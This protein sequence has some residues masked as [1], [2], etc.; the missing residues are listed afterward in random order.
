MRRMRFTRESLRL[1]G[2]FALGLA[3]L[4]LFA[5]SLAALG[6]TLPAADAL[7]THHDHADHGWSE[8][9]RVTGKPFHW[10]GPIAPGRTVTIRGIHGGVHVEPAVG[11]QVAVDARK[12][13]RRS[14][15][16]SVEIEVVEQGGNLIVCARYPRPDG[17]L[18]DCDDR[19]QEVRDNDVA[20][21][22][23][24]R[25]PAG[26]NLVA[27]TINGRIDAQDLGGDVEA[28]TVNG[29]IHVSATGLVS[30]TTVNGSVVARLGSP[31]IASD[32]EFTT[33]NGRVVVVL[34]SA[35]DAEVSARTVHGGIATD[36]PLTTRG[37]WGNRRMSGTLGKGGHQVRIETVNGGIELRASGTPGVI[38]ASGDQQDDRD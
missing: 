12:T 2:S 28:T 36:F 6:L 11:S 17:R 5:L 20:V 16:E 29:S 33:V 25:I 27:R 8:R 10:S 30:A 37:R 13:G 22:F 1:A 23:D 35:V 38:R 18:N 19:G 24:V 32:L 4:T 21:D 15:P 7:A 14:D 9:G 3:L 26:V 34:P 31:R